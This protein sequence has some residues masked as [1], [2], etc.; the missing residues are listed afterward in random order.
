MAVTKF[1]RRTAYDNVA[2]GSATTSLECVLPDASGAKAG[3]VP[4]TKTCITYAHSERLYGAAPAIQNF[5]VGTITATGER[6]GG[7]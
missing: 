6:P 2:V 5:I 4:P 7:A 1:S 3:V